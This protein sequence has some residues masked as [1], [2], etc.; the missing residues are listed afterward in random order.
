MSTGRTKYKISTLM[1]IP[2]AAVASAAG[3][4][5][6]GVRLRPGRAAYFGTGRKPA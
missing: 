1:N 2:G 5:G 3:S 4:C 6:R